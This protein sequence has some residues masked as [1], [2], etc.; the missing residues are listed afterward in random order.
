VS[1]QFTTEL[2]K[3]AMKNVETAAVFVDEEEG[4]FSIRN[5]LLD[6]DE[7]RKNEKRGKPDTLKRHPS[8]RLTSETQYAF[9]RSLA[10][11]L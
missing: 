2:K 5:Q 9:V 3:K 1:D 7:K 6:V 8:T 4:V 10:L 11:S